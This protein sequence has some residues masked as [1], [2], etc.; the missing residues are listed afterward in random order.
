MV[1]NGEQRNVLGGIGASVGV[2]WAPRGGA[3]MFLG[4]YTHNVD[5][6]GRVIIPSKFRDSV[7][8]GL[9]LTRGVEHCLSA[10]PLPQWQAITDKLQNLP[11]TPKPARDYARL[12]YSYATELKPDRQGRILIPTNLIEYAKI[13]SEVR[14]VGVRDRFEIWAAARWREEL[15][16][17]NDAGE[18]IAAALADLGI[19]V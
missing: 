13:D 7:V 18:D 14:I 3:A 10:Y 8:D 9:V 19:A 12:I 17:L 11:A 6:S 4:Q 15:G 5:E 2:A 16:R 1:Y